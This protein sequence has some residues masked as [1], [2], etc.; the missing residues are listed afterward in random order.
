MNEPQYLKEQ[1]DKFGNINKSAEQGGEIPVE[2]G[3]FDSIEISNY[4]KEKGFPYIVDK[5]NIRN[6]FNMDSK[7]A[8]KA[9]GIEQFIMEQIQEEGLRDSLISYETVLDRYLTK[10]PESLERMVQSKNSLKA[11]EFLF[12]EAALEEELSNES[13]LDIMQERLKY[14]RVEFLKGQ[15]KQALALI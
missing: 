5:L 2:K 13:Y 7:I 1:L 3:Q 12:G 11:L 14:Q 10:L 4:S 6:D 15:L 8:A 9:H